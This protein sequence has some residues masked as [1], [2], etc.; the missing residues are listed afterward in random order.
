[1]PTLEQWCNLLRV[2]G[3]ELVP[4]RDL[5]RLLR[6]SKRAARS[7]LTVG[8]RRGWV[9]ELYHDGKPCIR[10]TTE[11]LVVATKWPGIREAAEK[12]YREDDGK[13]R[14]DRLS[15]ALEKL[16]ASLP[17]EH[18]HFP[19]GYGAA[20]ARV[21]GGY[22]QSWSPVKRVNGASASELP[23]SALVSQALVAFAMAYEERCSV[24]LSLSAMVVRAIPPEGRHARELAAAPGHLSALLRDGLLT[25]A[26]A[27]RRDDQLI[28]LSPAGRLVYEQYPR[29]VREVESEWRDS[30]GDKIV[31]DVRSSL[32]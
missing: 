30:F 9:E 2:L 23:L 27:R 6:L 17:L 22:G 7:N 13:G 29:L 12:T 26:G 25:T 21:T 10:M 31:E 16:V 15:N 28:C 24:A 11:G 19:A 1:M 8:Q 32:S 4:R 14:V 5:S 18:P 20:D 3:G